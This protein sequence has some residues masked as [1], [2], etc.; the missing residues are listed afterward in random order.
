MLKAA[1]AG[2]LALAL[3]GGCLR[4]AEDAPEAAAPP[5]LQAPATSHVLISE[6]TI[7]RLKHALHLTAA[8]E[9]YWPPVEAALH[10][11]AH[12]QA[13]G[14]PETGG[15]MRRLARRAKRVALNAIQ[16]RQVMTAA[17][18]LIQSL[19]DEQKRDALA[20]ARGLGLGNLSL[21]Y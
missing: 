12:H 1:L 19:S 10:E 5:Q 20:F 18:P 15:V 3:S 14:E 6:A 4:A 16:L 13:Q 21:A 2:I 9:A 7:A 17:A 8:Q 11:L